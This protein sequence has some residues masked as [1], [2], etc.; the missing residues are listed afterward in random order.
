MSTKS[1]SKKTKF[2]I[3]NKKEFLVTYA[4]TYWGALTAEHICDFYDKF[5][6]WDYIVGVEQGHDALDHEHA[7]VYLKY[8]GPVRSGFSTRTETC[9]D[10]QLIFNEELTSKFISD[11]WPKNKNGNKITTA[12][13]NIR[14]KGDKEDPNCKNSYTM[15]DYVTKQRKELEKK[16]W[17]IYS[18]FD[19]ESYLNELESKYRKCEKKTQREMFTEKE[20]EFCEW[21]RKNILDNPTKTKFEIEK[22]ILEDS[23]LAYI[24]M[25]KHINYK[26]VLNDY[27][28]NK[29]INKPPRVWNKFWVPLKMKEAL[30][31]LN[32]FVMMWH[33]GQVKDGA[34]PRPIFVSGP[35]GC[36]KTSLFASIGDFCYWCNS[37]NFANYE[38]KPSYN[39]FDDYDGNEDSK[40][41]S[42]NDGWNYIKPWVG[43]Q[44]VVSISGKFKAPMTVINNRPCVFISNYRFEDRF[45]EAAQKYWRDVGGFIIDLPDNIKLFEKPDRRTI[46]GYT[47]WVEYD[48]RN[49]WYY[50]NKISPTL[51]NKENEP[52]TNDNSYIIIDE[53]TQQFLP[54]PP[55]EITDENDPVDHVLLEEAEDFDIPPANSNVLGR[56]LKRINPFGISS[57]NT[58]RTRT[59]SDEDL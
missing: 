19:W 37:W 46:G 53:D 2:F 32:N 16:D 24:F 48:T 4:H 36:G 20:M 12:H 45:G 57:S 23:K 56:L 5:G 38:S 44:H 51:E 33:L 59:N 40:N 43:G 11:D 50:L 26:S 52:P 1:N 17:K 15:V 3:N 10:I 30:D 14:F 34:R 29:P 47:N 22:E 7:H 8:K 39:I 25:S 21:L 28:K 35:G 6:F 55:S 27:F 9:W 13:P 58:K 42:I 31:Y 18:N 49:T 41:N 54:E